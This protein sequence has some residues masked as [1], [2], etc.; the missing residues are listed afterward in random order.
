MKSKDKIIL[1]KILKYIDEL[2]YFIDGF[3]K[4]NFN[5]TEKL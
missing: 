4:E 2:N 1:L 5:V 3:S